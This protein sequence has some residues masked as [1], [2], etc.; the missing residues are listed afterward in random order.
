MPVRCVSWTWHEKI[1]GLSTGEKIEKLLR[2]I[3]VIDWTLDCPPNANSRNLFDNG[4]RSFVGTAKM[5]TNAFSQLPGGQQAIGFHNSLLGMHPLGLDR[6]EPGT[7][8]GQKE[9]QDA[10]PFALLL[11]LAVVLTNP[12]S[13]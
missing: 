1:I 12:G 13:Y 6:I 5:S 10:H 2:T 11:D 8:G 9:G 7:F 3:T 4:K